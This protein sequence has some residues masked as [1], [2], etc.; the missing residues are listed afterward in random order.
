VPKSVFRRRSPSASFR[1]IAM[2]DN[3]IKAAEQTYSGFLTLT[4][5]GTIACIL[6]AGLVVL[7]IS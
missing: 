7:L 1:E 3:D 2:A 5:W 6:V 4:K